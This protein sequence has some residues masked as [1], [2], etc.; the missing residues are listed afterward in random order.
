MTNIFTKNFGLLVEELYAGLEMLHKCETLDQQKYQK[1]SSL[2]NRMHSRRLVVSIASHALN[3]Q[4]NL[5][6]NYRVIEERLVSLRS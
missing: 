6:A 4:V 3:L 5:V 1:L 2:K